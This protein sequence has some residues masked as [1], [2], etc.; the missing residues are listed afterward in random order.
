MHRCGLGT[1]RWTRGRRA[2]RAEGDWTFQVEAWSDPWPPGCTTAEIKLPG[3]PRRRAGERGG[4]PAV[5]AGRG[6]RSRRPARR[7]RPPA[8]ASPT[9]CATRAVPPRPGWPRPRPPRCSAC[10]DRHPLRE[11]VTAS[12]A[13]PAAGRPRAGAVGSW[14]EFFPR[15]EGAVI[16]PTGT[17]TPR[18]GT[19]RTAAERLP[20]VAA[21]GFDVVYLPPI[22]PIGT[23]YRKGPNN[24]LT[25]GPTTP[26]RRGRSARADGRPRRHP[27]RPRARSTTS[28]PSWPRASELGLEVALDFALQARPTTRGSPSTRSGSRTGP[29]ARSPT[30][31]T[32]RRSTRTSTRSTST[33]TPPGIYAEALRVAAA[34]D[35]ARACGSSGSTTRTPSRCTSGS[36]SS[37]RSAR[38]TPTCSSSPRRSPA[39]R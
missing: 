8:G 9:R 18:S 2:R 23:A 20:A 11:L 15:S 4:R 19:F 6:R 38:P 24:T 37:P 26:A 29:T 36:G 13:L 28:T 27:P 12:A 10:L 22:H 32:R 1:D 7:R 16:D 35:R 5:R 17:W 14:Y 31:R 21:M 39:R 33:T 34:L 3:R 25:P 30:P